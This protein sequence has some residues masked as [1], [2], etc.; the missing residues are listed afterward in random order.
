MWIVLTLAVSL[1][2]GPCNSTLCDM[3]PQ[4]RSS[5]A[6]YPEIEASGVIKTYPTKDL[7]LKE[8]ADVFSHVGVCVEASGWQKSDPAW[9]KY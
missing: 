8:L 9:E 1:V 4:V 6:F 3:S 7:C 5:S 2:T